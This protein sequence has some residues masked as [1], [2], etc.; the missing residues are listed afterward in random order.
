MKKGETAVLT[1]RADYAYGDSGSPPKIPGGAT[2]QFEV[3]TSAPGLRSPLPTS[4]PGLAYTLITSA[5]GIS[6]TVSQGPVRP[7][8]PSL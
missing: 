7:A 6:P 3:R 4:A 8:D 5:P 2:L 1:C